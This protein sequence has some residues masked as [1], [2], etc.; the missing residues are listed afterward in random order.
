[1]EDI[2]DARYYQKDKSL[3]LTTNNQLWLVIDAEN[4]KLLEYFQ[5]QFPPNKIPHIQT[6]VE[7]F[8][9]DELYNLDLILNNNNELFF[10][11]RDNRENINCIKIQ[12]HLPQKLKELE[13]LCMKYC[14]VE[15]E[16]YLLLSDKYG[17]LMEI[18]LTQVLPFIV[19]KS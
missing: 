5:Y 12:E 17:Y 13:F 7:Q 4:Y 10:I 6:R 8:E 14:H 18:K 9:I 15:N 16:K 11:S 19:K 2:I 1:M 3:T